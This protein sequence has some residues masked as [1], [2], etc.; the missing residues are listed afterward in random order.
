MIIKKTHKDK[1][2]I[3][4]PFLLVIMSIIIQISNKSLS[5]ILKLVAVFYMFAYSFLKPLNKNLVNALLL[6]LPF[7]IYNYIISYN[8]TAALEDGIRY[9]FPISVIFYSYSIRT[10]YKFLFKCLIIFVII[11]DFWQIINYIY[12]LKGETQWFYF[13]HEPSGNRY[14]NQTSGIIRATGIVVFFSMFGFLNGISYF[15]IYKYYNGKHKKALLLM[16]LISML[17][18]FSYKII[19]SFFLIFFFSYKNKL[20]IL[21]GFLI[22]TLA[23]VFF[24]PN[25]IVSFIG[26]INLRLE[27]YIFEGDSARSESYR[28]MIDEI[29]NLNLFGRGIG[30]FGGPASVTYNSPVYNEVNFNWY[31][32]NSLATTDTYYPHLFVELGLIGACLYLLILIIPIIRTTPLNKM[33]MI[34]IIYFLLFFDAVF[35]FSLNNLEYLIVSIILIYPI[36]EYNKSQI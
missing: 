6:F 21:N 11:N 5:S 30:S 18:S 17:L 26:D 2:F 13:L 31:D 27:K 12:W 29:L 25:K 36:V 14:F 34:Y 19:G 9:I 22:A 1:L 33:G 28:V 3:L 32:T 35:S 24:I 7:L 23:I 20:K 10:H 8:K 16:T 4:I 15:I